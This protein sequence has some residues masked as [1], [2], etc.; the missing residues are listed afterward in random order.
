MIVTARLTAHAT[1]AVDSAIAPGRD[2]KPRPARARRNDLRMIEERAT[3]TTMIFPRGE[4][5]LAS[6]PDAA[7]RRFDYEIGF[8]DKHGESNTAAPAQR[9]QIPARFFRAAC[10]PATGTE[11]FRVSA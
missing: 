8:V 3:L 10:H 5:F 11:I 6:R 1:D 7:S 2:E 4:T 9:R